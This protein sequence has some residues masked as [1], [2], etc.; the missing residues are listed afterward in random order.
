MRQNGNRRFAFWNVECSCGQSPIFSIGANRLLSGNTSSCGCLAREKARDRFKTHGE[1]RTKIYYVWNS[2]MGRCYNE[3]HKYYSYYGER[4][5][6][7]ETE[8]HVFEIFRDWALAN[9][10][11]EGLEI[12][13]IDTDGNYGPSNCRFVPHSANQRNKRKQKGC[14]SQYQGVYKCDNGR[15][16]AQGRIAGKTMSLGRFNSEAEAALARDAFY[17]EHSPNGFHRNLP[18]PTSDQIGGQPPDPPESC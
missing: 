14:S 18:K 16:Q 15:W 12:D 3:T 17:D 1:S 9:G 10:Y 13:R 11:A 8:W 2:F 4:G 5:I 6:T 7:V